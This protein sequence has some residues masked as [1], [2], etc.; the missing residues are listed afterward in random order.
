MARKPKEALQSQSAQAVTPHSLRLE[1]V[2]AGSLDGNPQNWRRHPDEQKRALREV[3]ADPEIGWAGACLYNERTK[4]LIDGHA[5]KESVDPDT[6]IPVLVGSWSEE[7]E[8][9]ILVTLDPLSAMATGDADAYRAL[10][11]SVDIDGLWVRDLIHATQQGLVASEEE[12]DPEPDADGAETLPEMECQPF[13]H[14]DYVMLMFRNDQDFQRVCELLQIKRVQITYPGG[15][16]KVGIGRVV[17]GPKAVEL[18]MA[19]GRREG[20]RP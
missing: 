1:W 14:H 19:A 5:R 18:L 7:A 3:I 8:K 13:E 16:Q 10:V 6:V 12:A 15:L 4:R 9:K 20:G 17:D 11:N 2:E